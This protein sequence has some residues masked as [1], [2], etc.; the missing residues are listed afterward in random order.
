METKYWNAWF[1]HLFLKVMDLIKEGGCAPEDRTRFSDPSCLVCL[2][3]C[4]F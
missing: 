2:F 3:V 4:L 1:G